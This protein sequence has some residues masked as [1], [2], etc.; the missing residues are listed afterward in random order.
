MN[1]RAVRADARV[2]SIDPNT[3]TVSERIGFMHE[4]KAIALGRI[5]AVDGQN[6]P[7]KVTRLFPKKTVDECIDEGKSP[8]K[9]VVGWTRLRGCQIEGIEALALEVKGTAQ[10]LAELEA[11]ENIDRREIGPLEKAKFVAALADAARARVAA[12]HGEDLSNQ[13]MAIKA[14]WMRAAEPKAGIQGVDKALEEETD[15]TCCTMQRVYGWQESVRDAFGLER[16]AI[17]RFI[18]LYRM[19]VEPFPRLA[20]P[21]AKHPVV[22]ENLTQLLKVAS[23]RDEALRRRVIEALLADPEISADEAIELAGVGKAKPLADKASHQKHYDAVHSNWKRLDVEHQ[24]AFLPTLV[25]ML[26]PDMKRR[27]REMIDEELGDE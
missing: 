20:E 14:R 21:L 13:Q 8:W 5:I 23:Q 27:V 6:D 9:L 18:K 1:A 10:E 26:T 11:S 12:M 15:D 17:W 25:G 4:D 7:I 2:I 19:L 24:R 16:T 22:G 3:V